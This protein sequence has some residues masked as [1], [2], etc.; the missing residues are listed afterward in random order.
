MRQDYEYINHENNSFQKLSICIELELTIHDEIFA[1]C[2]T[3]SKEKPD[4]VHPVGFLLIA[5]ISFGSDFD[6]CSSRSGHED[7]ESLKRKL[8]PTRPHGPACGHRSGLSRG[9]RRQHRIA[10]PG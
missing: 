4:P 2:T 9:S 3:A 5:Y 7:L 1:T 6:N 10:E 8:T